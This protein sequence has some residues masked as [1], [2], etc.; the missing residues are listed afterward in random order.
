MDC[1]VSMCGFIGE[2]CDALHNVIG[3]CRSGQNGNVGWLISFG[4]RTWSKWIHLIWLHS[5]ILLNQ[6]Y[7]WEP[8]LCAMSGDTQPQTHPFTQ[9]VVHLSIYLSLYLPIYSSSHLS[10]YP[11]FL[12]CIFPFICPL[13]FQLFIS[14]PFSLYFLLTFLLSTFLI[15]I[16]PSLHPS[17]LLPFIH[18]SILPFFLPPIQPH[19]YLLTR[20]LL[21]CLL[22]THHSTTEFKSGINSHQCI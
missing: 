14:V 13:S 16:L 11:F 17:F 9:K 8:G 15:F 6:L 20:P 4:R 5:S 2:L 10:F 12:P 19:S 22:N 21:T 1:S 3:P 7:G 18:P